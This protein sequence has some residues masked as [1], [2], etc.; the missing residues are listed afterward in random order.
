MRCIGTDVSKEGR[1]RLL[2]F[3]DPAKGGLEEDVGA[4]TFGLD[5]R[6]VM[7]G[8]D[9]KIASFLVAVG[10][11]VGTASRVGLPDPACPMDEDFTKAPVVGLIGV[12]VT[13]VP[14]A[15]NPGCVS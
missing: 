4:K 13:K 12:F 11:E 7:Q 9:I 2:L 10:R 15:K 1:F 14:L 5:D 8:G 3:P 6:L